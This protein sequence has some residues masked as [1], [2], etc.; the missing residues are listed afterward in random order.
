[1]N[2]IRDMDT[3][4]SK[5]ENLQVHVL[6]FSVLREELGTPELTVELEAPATGADLLDRLAAEYEAV[7]LRR[8]AIRLAVEEAFASEEVV[9]EEGQDVALVTP[10]SGG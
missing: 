7:R 4:N 6:L 3:A 10:V 9:L 2:A 8:P 1:M 5:A